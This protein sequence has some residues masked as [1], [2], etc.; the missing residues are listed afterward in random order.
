MPMKPLPAPDVP[1]RTESERFDNALRQVFSVSKDDLL[2][3]EAR[4]KRARTKKK[5]MTEQKKHK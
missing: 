1:G 3:R 2:K 4:D 5:R